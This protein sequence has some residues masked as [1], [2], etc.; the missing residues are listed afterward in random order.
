[1]QQ[2]RLR[3]HASQPEPS[4]ARPVGEWEAAL[5]AVAIAPGST[6]ASFWQAKQ[7]TRPARE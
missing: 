1:M 7:E 3:H 6:C 5:P 2:A 4:A